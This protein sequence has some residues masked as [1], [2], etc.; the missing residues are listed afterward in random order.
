[1]S[2]VKKIVMLA[3]AISVGGIT[4]AVVGRT[5]AGEAAEQES[6]TSQ[7]SDGPA[8]AEDNRGRTRNSVSLDAG[9]DP[10]LLAIES[11]LEERISLSVDKK[12]LEEA[13]G[14]LRTYTGLNI[15]LDPRALSKAGIT[16]SWP[17]SL[18]AQQVPLKTVIKLLLR[19][20]DL[21]YKIEDEAVLITSPDNALRA[22]SPTL[23]YPKDILRG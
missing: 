6:R 23:T 1:M 19:P 16:A 4:F 8:P 18:S 20:L 14:F 12:P 10:H 5:S 22:P 3:T 9:K 13:V 7:A 17:V 21:T 15:V 11:K 2:H